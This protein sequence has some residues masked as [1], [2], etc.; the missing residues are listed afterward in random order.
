[1]KNRDLLINAIIQLSP[2]MD[3]KDLIKLACM[4]HK[5]LDDRLIKIAYSLKYSIKNHSK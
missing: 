5:Q 4:S 1:M 2:K 3:R